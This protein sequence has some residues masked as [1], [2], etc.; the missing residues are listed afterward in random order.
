[1]TMIWS[2]LPTNK[3]DAVGSCT[4]PESRPEARGG[5]T[6][7]ELL[8]VIAIIAILAALLLPALVKAKI[9]AQ[10]I[11]CMN[12]GNQMVKAWT[13]YASDNTD[14]CCN[15]YGVAQTAVEVQR[16]SYN[17][18]CVDNMDWTT[19]QQNTNVALLQLGQLGPYMAKS[20]AAYKCPA[21]IFL[22]ALQ[23]QARFQA[24][25]RSYSMNDFLGLFSQCGICGGT[26][27]S[28]SGTDYTYEA[29]NQFN[30]D[31]P[32]YLKLASIP[33]PSQIYVML[34]EHPD[35][36]NDGY[37]DDGD[38]GSPAAPTSWGGSDTPASYHN[39]ACGFAFSDA[40]SE[41]HKWQVSGTICPVVAGGG[42]PD[43]T[44]G[45]PANYTDR[46]WVCG[47]ACIK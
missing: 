33:Q 14:R 12:N 36:I 26:G 25:V 22:S 27:E 47:H 17:T 9:Q 6:L 31:W 35:S 15:N 41:I 21:D 10:S 37:F 34:E 11:Q 45:T 23:V 20:V 2:D 19:D 44:L 32:Q 8:V 13:M 38:Q 5:F 16:R 42:L 1:M 29:K 7:I 30:S 46:I 39:G 4:A 28:G 18:W 43:A 40:H 24:R 3:P